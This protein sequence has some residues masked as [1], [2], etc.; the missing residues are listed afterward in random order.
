MRLVRG[1][2]TMALA[3]ALAI[4]LG[5]CGG[6]SSSSS[7]SSSSGDP[8]STALQTPGVRQVV[9][10]SQHADLTVV[11]PTCDQAQTLKPGSTKPPPGSNT[12]VI[13]KGA[14]TETIAVQPCQG[15]GGGS[16]GSGSTPPAPPSSTILLTPGGAGTSQ[17]SSGSQSSSSS[18]SGSSQPNQLVLPNNSSITTLIVPPCTQSSSDQNQSSNKSL[19]LPGK[20]TSVTAPACTVPQ[21]S[22][23]S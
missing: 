13:P 21:Q 11:I 20:G 9:I 6:S 10:P 4:G 7:S 5:A 3:G 8:V 15:G 2:A 14:Q 23:S 12:V 18:S 16:S 17:Q 1:G 19:A 22:S